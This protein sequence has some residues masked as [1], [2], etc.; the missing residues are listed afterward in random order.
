MKLTKII[1]VFMMVFSLSLMARE[2]V[3]MSF[4]DL[5]IEDFIK[6]VSKITNKNILVNYKVAGKIDL[7]TTTAIYD[8][9]VMDIL[10]SVLES[11]GYTL[12]QNGSVYEII[13][14]VDAAQQ[15]LK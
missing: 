10:I 3:N 4:S 8:D 11:K 7:I 9:E 12:V 1:T 5:S 6:L 2:Q 13:R 15:N 14:S